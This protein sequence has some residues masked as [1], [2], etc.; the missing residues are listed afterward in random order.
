MFGIN[1]ARRI[2]T[3]TKEELLSLTDREPADPYAHLEATLVLNPKCSRNELHTN[4]TVFEAYLRNVEIVCLNQNAG[5]AHLEECRSSLGPLEAAFNPFWFEQ[6]SNALVSE[7]TTLPNE[8]DAVRAFE[9][10]LI[11]LLGITTG[12]CSSSSF[13]SNNNNKRI[14]KIVHQDGGFHGADPS[15]QMRFHSLRVHELTVQHD[16]AE[17]LGTLMSSTSR[18]M[19]ALDGQFGFDH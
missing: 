9:Y 10:G 7:F 4:K 13:D 6:S 18:A 1:T 16:S 11:Q 12:N 3:G 2:R 17:R 8:T 19:Y 14:L 5:V 15:R